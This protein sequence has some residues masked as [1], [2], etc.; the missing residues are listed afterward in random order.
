M[1]AVKSTPDGYDSV[2]SGKAPSLETSDNEIDFADNAAF[3]HTVKTGAF[4]TDHFRSEWN[5][6]MFIDRSGDYT[7]KLCS[8]DGSRLMIN[9]LAVIDN[10]G[11]HGMRCMEETRFWSAGWHDLNV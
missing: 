9:E 6:K 3:I 10:W 11:L 5:G 1:G 7:F 8:D 2:I 4:P